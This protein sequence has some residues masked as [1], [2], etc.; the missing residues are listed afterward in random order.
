MNLNVRVNPGPQ[1]DEVFLTSDEEDENYVNRTIYAKPGLF[2]S[3]ELS[4]LQIE[5]LEKRSIAELAADL[6]L[7]QKAEQA[8]AV[9]AAAPAI[10]EPMRTAR[11]IAQQ[12]TQSTE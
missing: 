3:G 12:E 5:E 9:K 1:R 10:T 6:L 11:E 4:A 8:E 2:T 7:Q